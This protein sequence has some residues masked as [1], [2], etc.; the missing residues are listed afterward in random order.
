MLTDSVDRQ[1]I[2]MKSIVIRNRRIRRVVMMLTFAALILIVF[3]WTRVEVLR[4]GYEVTQ[5]HHEV[6]LLTEQR[7]AM[8]AEVA[9]L[10]SPERLQRVARD[11]FHM[12]LPRGDEIMYVTSDE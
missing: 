10:K 6:N 9:H 8:E 7:A 11:R 5:L 3:V 12:R 1:H 2:A 4:L